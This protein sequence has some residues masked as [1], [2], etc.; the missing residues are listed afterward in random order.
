MVVIYNGRGEGIVRVFIYFVYSS[1]KK[2]VLQYCITRKDIVQY[3][4]IINIHHLILIALSQEFL[5]FLF[6]V[7]YLCFH[8]LNLQTWNYLMNT[9]KAI[10]LQSH[11]IKHPNKKGP[12]YISSQWSLNKDQLMYS[13]QDIKMGDTLTPFLIYT[14][15]SLPLSEG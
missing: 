15:S 7:K 2:D 8:V 9:T 10:S 6:R 12:L 11:L 5:K 14:G 1:N 13:K 3:C 4:F